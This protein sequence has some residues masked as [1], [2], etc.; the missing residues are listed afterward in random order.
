[1]SSKDLLLS[2]RCRRPHVNSSHRK[3]SAANGRQSVREARVDCSCQWSEELVGQIRRLYT[4][5]TGRRYDGALPWRT[6]NVSTA[7][8]YTV[9][10]PGLVASGGRSKPR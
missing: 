8:L 6:L 9:C 7:V 2:R 1:M 4:P 10:A 5:V 3:R